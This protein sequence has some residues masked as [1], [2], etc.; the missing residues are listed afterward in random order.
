M[1]ANT[2]SREIEIIMKFYNNL[3]DTMDIDSLLPYFQ[4]VN[5]IPKCSLEEARSRDKVPKLL[6]IILSDLQTDNGLSFYAMLDI[7]E[8]HGTQAMRHLS[9]SMRELVYSD[10]NKSEY[11]I[12]CQVLSV[13]T[14]YGV[15]MLL[16][17]HAMYAYI[18]EC[19]LQIQQ[20]YANANIIFIHLLSISRPTICA[21]SLHVFCVEMIY[22]LH[23]QCMNNTNH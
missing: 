1:A 19:V 13:N 6:Q 16:Y 5:I 23:I 12:L 7:M 20:W 18:H 15:H 10:H 9:V 22:I 4:Q 14:S 3:C 11:Y 8:Q 21:Y 17:V 2:Q